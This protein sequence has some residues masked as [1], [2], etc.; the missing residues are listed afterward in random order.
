[1]LIK[2][3]F[4]GILC[5]GRGGQG[6]LRRLQYLADGAVIVAPS[7]YERGWNVNNGKSKVFNDNQ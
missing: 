1:M 5:L 3:R 7:G 4:D 2:I 6:N